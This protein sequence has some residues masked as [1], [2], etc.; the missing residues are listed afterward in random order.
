M[1]GSQGRLEAQDRN[2][3]LVYTFEP[4]CL[5]MDDM[6]LPQQERMPG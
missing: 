6:D 2:Q 1:K 5:H 3:F 4:V